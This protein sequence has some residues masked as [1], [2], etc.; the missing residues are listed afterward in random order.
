MRIAITGTPGTGK[1]TVAEIL[2]RKLKLPV[3]DLSTVIKEK[4]LYSEFDNERDAFIVDVEKLK[5]FFKDKDSFIA[6]GLVAHYI[7]SDFLIILRVNPE[8]LPKRL[9]ERGYSN[10][11]IRENQEA[12]RVAVIATEAIE[13]S[14]TK[15]FIHIDTTNKPPELVAKLIMKGLE[16]E[17]I[18]EEVDWLK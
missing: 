3:Y 5:N 7:P 14:K 4:K 2:S 16:K 9:S 1:S 12:E 15:K 17:P 8:M 13:S 18:F 11:K 6:E 10:R